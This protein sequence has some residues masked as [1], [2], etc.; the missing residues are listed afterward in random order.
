MHK[1]YIDVILRQESN[2][3][4]NLKI[5]ICKIKIYSYA[6]ILKNTTFSLYLSVKPLLYRYRFEKT[7]FC[8]FWNQNLLEEIKSSFYSSV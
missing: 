4:K 7:S 8:C 3:S 6:N 2:F 1:F 5:D